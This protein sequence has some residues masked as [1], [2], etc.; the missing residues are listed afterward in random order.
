LFSA[1]EVYNTTSTAS[2]GNRGFLIVLEAGKKAT[3]NHN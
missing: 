1:K 2:N 3:E